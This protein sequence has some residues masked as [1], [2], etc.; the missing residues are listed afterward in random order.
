MTER[1]HE[2]IMKEVEIVVETEGTEI[3]HTVGINCKTIMKEIGSMTKTGHTAEI[4]HTVEIGH[5]VEIGHRA[6][7]T[8]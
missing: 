6:T 4:G 8:K 2:I 3:D 1:D 7:T 5:I